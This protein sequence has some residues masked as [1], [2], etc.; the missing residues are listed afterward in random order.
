ML[1]WQLCI[2]NLDVYPF[3]SSAKTE[4]D[5]SFCNFESS[6]LKYMNLPF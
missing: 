2:Y 4:L 6:K 3:N 5:A 1:A